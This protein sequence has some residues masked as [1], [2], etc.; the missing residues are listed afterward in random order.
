MTEEGGEKKK[1]KDWLAHEA[2]GGEL[3]FDSTKEKRR[4][5]CELREKERKKRGVARFSH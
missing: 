1:E 3:V 2:Q 5:N 4:E